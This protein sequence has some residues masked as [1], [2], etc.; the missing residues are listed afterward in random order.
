MIKTI[1]LL[2]ANIKLKRDIV[3]IE[4]EI[5]VATLFS[6]RSTLRNISITSAER[7]VFI[8]IINK[9]QDEIAKLSEAK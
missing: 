9:Q 6:A 1:K 4:H 5:A 2:W 7:E 8:N 3:A